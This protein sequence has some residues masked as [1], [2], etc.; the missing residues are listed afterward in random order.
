MPDKE[1]IARNSFKFG[2]QCCF[3]NE[4]AAERW[5]GFIVTQIGKKLNS[6]LEVLDKVST[7]NFN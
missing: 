6:G 2:W 4:A 1:E 5:D 7:F 3:L